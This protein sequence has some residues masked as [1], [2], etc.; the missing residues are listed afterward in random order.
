[1]TRAEY[2]SWVAFYDWEASEME[3]AASGKP[4]KKEPTIPAHMAAE[5]LGSKVDGWLRR[6]WVKTSD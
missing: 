5:Y 6:G 3:A 1:M 2:L 4:R